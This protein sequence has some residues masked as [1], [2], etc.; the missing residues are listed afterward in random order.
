M[1][2]TSS[3]PDLFRGSTSSF[4]FRFIDLILRSE[5]ARVSK[6]PP[7]VSGHTFE[8]GCGSPQDEAGESVNRCKTWMAGT[9]PA[10]TGWR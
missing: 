2:P 5:L 9:R 4:A 8:T 1:K 6:E 7:V 3:S 10:M